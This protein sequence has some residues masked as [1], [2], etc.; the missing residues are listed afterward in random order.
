MSAEVTDG[1][2]LKPVQVKE[3]LGI[4]CLSSECCD[5]TTPRLGAGVLDPIPTPKR[6][7]SS[8][9]FPMDF[10]AQAWAMLYLPASLA[11]SHLLGEKY[12]L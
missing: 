12:Q 11:C 1:G 3:D 6:W 10:V 9:K 7:V 2:W 5:V 8:T 4:C